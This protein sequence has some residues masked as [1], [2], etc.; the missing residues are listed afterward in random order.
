[1]IK[2][3]LITGI[4]GQDGSRFDANHLKSNPSNAKKLLNWTAKT[5]LYTIV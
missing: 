2:N 1:M 4:V 3:V 5:S